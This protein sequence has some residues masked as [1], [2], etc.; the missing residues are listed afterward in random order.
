MTTGVHF[1][2]LA[3]KKKFEA[4]FICQIRLYSAHNSGLVLLSTLKPSSKV[5]CLIEIGNEGN[6]KMRPFCLL[7]DNVSSENESIKKPQLH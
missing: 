4:I 6:Q 5:K 2:C 1:D 7:N 3:T